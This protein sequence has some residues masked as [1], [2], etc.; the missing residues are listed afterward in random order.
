VAGKLI[1]PIYK[2]GCIGRNF[3]RKALIYSIENKSVYTL[4]W[5]FAGKREKQQGDA[6]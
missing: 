6:D 4:M 3:S 1:L 5:F 2:T